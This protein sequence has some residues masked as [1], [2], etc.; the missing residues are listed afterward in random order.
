MN[1][2]VSPD[3]RT[4]AFDL[5]G[6]I[7]TM[8][9]AGGTPTRISSGLAF[10]MQ[11]RFSP[12]GRLIAFTSDRGGG[13]NIWVMNA[14]GSAPRAITRESFRLLNAPT[15]SRDGQYIAARKHFT[16]QRSP[17]HRRDL[18]LP[19]LGRRRRR[20]ADRAAQSA[21][22]EGIGRARFLRAT[23]RRSSSAATPRPATSSNMPR[24]RTR[25]CSRSSA[26][27]WRPASA[28]R[29]PAAPAARSGRRPRPTA[30]ISPTSTAPAATRRLCVK[31]PALGR[32][33]PGLC[34]SRPG[35]AGDLGGARRLSQH[36]LDARQPA[37]IVFWAGG[38]IR[39]VDRDGSG[40]AEIP[41][42][43]SDT[44]VVI[45]PPR[46]QVE[47]APATVTT[48]MPR[49][50]AVSPDGG[51]VV[52]ETLGRLYIRDVA[53]VGAPRLLTA[54]D[55]DF[56]LFPTWS[57]DGRTDRLRLVERP[58]ASAKSA[59]SPRTARTCARSPSSPAITAAR[60][61]RPT[62][63]TIVYEASGSQGLTSNRWS[64]ATGIFRVPAAGGPSTRILAEGGNPQFGADS[65]PRL[66]RGQRA[67]EAEADQRR[68]ERRQPPRARRRARWS[69]N[70]SCRPTA[71]R[72]LFR[73]DYNL[74]ATPFYGGVHPL[75][76][77]ARGTGLPLTRVTANGGTY[78]SW[79]TNGRLAWS[80]GPTLYTAA[81][82]DLIRSA[83]GG[84]A[85]SPA[86]RRHLA[87]RSPSPPTC[88]P[89]R[90]LWSARGSSPW[91]T[92]TAAS[93]TT[94][95]S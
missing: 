55:G 24:I 62:A 33:A 56:Q 40:A 12:D 37:R 80:L 66:R 10:D 61:S 20:A 83:P 16:T 3:G 2:D 13:D 60:A 92:T 82:S 15:W 74:F 68:S 67:A 30:I 50:A 64:D 28:A 76:V 21:L 1:V 6:D 59:P 69:P 86:D 65:E 27:T 94:A 71:A 35:S 41:F 38:K 43:V 19:C 58:A 52:F 14:D 57:R 73:E 84:T 22:P 29:S 63:R 11:P 39:R 8:P 48:R 46:P 53:G 51:R 85:Y 95:S 89:A 32:G 18:A 36:G 5:L 47:A 23:A 44:S 4:I 93:S 9:I 75:D 49:F 91:P 25:R 87:R 31:R 81:V 79:T 88:R 17:R 78:P 34:R 42:Q 7:Y 45:D 54:Q 77:S 72:S 70:M 26:T 90:S